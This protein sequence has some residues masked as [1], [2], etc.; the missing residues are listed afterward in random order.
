[1]KVVIKNAIG[2]ESEGVI[3]HYVVDRGFQDFT[4]L[5]VIEDR[6]TVFSYQS[7]EVCPTIDIV[8]NVSSHNSSL[9][10]L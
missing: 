1:M 3:I 5:C 2:N 6:E 8:A 7:E 9:P 4:S 10:S